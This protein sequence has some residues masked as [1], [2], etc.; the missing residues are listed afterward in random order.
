MSPGGG[1]RDSPAARR[2]P[3]PWPGRRDRRRSGS[4]QAGAGGAPQATTRRR[5]EAA[6]RGQ[7]ASRGP[8]ASERPAEGRSPGR[9]KRPAAPGAGRVKALAGTPAADPGRRTGGRRQASR[10][11]PLIRKTVVPALTPGVQCPR[12][13]ARSAGVVMTL[14]DR[15]TLKEMGVAFSLGLMIFT[16]VLLTNKI[17]RLVELIV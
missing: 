6:C 10:A 4:W 1:S 17:L 9:R 2:A 14:V 7:P 16:F 11:P 15:A 13:F 5:P 12:F 8:L 3:G